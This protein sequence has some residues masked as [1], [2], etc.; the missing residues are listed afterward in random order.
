MDMKDNKNN[1]NNNNS[2]V[3]GQRM[4]I[5]TYIEILKEKAAKNQNSLD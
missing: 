1:N 3:M 5:K 2:S 4:K